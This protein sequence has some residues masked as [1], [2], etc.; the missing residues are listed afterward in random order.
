VCSSDLSRGATAAKITGKLLPGKIYERTFR[1]K[2]GST[3][4]VY[5][6]DAVLKNSDGQ[7]VGIRS[8]IQDITQHKD[9]EHRL[10]ESEERYRLLIENAA[11]SI[12]VIQN[13]VIKFANFQAERFSGYSKRELLGKSILDLVPPEDSE[14]ALNHHHMRVRGQTMP[15][16]ADTVRVLRKDGAIRSAEVRGT[17]ITWGGASATLNFYTDITERRR[18]EEALAS[19]REEKN[20]LL[21][22]LQHRIKNSLTMISSLIDLESNRSTDTETHAILATLRDRVNSITRLYSLMHQ[23]GEIQRI[24]L[25]HYFSH[26]V[27]SL[28]ETYVPDSPQ[29]H[30]TEEYEQI[31]IDAKPAA[32]CGLILNELVTNAFKYAFPDGRAGTVHIR[33]SS[34]DGTLAISV[35]DDGVGPPD[36]FSVERSTGFGM[37]ILQLLV[38]QLDG[39]I[40]Y[41]RTNQ[42]IFTIRLML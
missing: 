10:H 26:I 2:D 38:E 7:I 30:I 36:G 28:S 8:T 17:V 37:R 27:R 11:E 21:K 16:E 40:E 39:R 9:A 29:I 4:P 19:A 25:D 18:A 35:A 23:T 31:L 32:S 24:R 1:R 12:V 42:T 41:Q 13:G 20:A 14:R 22:E 3:F 33:A 6:D 34:H 15:A 5:V